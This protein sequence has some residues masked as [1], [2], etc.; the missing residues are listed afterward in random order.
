[1]DVADSYSAVARRYSD[2]IFDE[3]QHKPLD[4]A[5]LDRF[6]ES[7]PRPGRICDLGC[8]PGQVARYLWQS[9]LEVLG[10]DIS[11][12][13]IEQ[14]RRLNPQLTFQH[15]D[16]LHLDLPA[17]ALTGV[18]AFYSLIHI[19]RPKVV[20]APERNQTSAAPRRPTSIFLS[21]WLGDCAPR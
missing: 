12:G 20:A 7:M 11:P 13:M 4:R 21:R 14:A 1:M 6:A 19:A 16:M 15:G 18:V 10:I 9:G 8:G 2:Q 5:L 3:L 17:D